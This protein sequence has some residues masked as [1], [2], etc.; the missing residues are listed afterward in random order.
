MRVAFGLREL[1]R[2]AGLPESIRATW[3]QATVQTCVVAGPPKRA[4]QNAPLSDWTW[5]S[6]GPLVSRLASSSRLCGRGSSM[7][8]AGDDGGRLWVHGGDGRRL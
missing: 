5:F 4:P 8:V 6:D 1:R 3:P 7:A 2:A